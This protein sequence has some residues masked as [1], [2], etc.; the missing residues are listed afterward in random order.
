MKSVFSLLPEQASTVAGQVDAIYLFL[1]AV[2]IFCM[3]FA[4]LL[5]LVFSIRYRR[6]A[7]V[8]SEQPHEDSR[9]EIFA[10]VCMLVLLMTLFGW[11]AKVYFHSVRPPA[12]AMEIMVTGKQWMWKLQHPQGKREINELHVPVGRPIQLTMTSEDVI[13]S[14]FIPAFRIKQDV[15]PVATRAFGLK[16]PRSEN[17]TFLRGILRHR[18][19]HDGRVGHGDDAGRL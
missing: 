10:G 8:E 4:G 18:A 13:H 9:L 3:I 1:V 16:P 2:S 17:I 7:G 5:V 14:F 11:G 12:D 6:R 19:F 15:L